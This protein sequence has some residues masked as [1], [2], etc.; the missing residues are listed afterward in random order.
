MEK[1]RVRISALPPAKQGMQVRKEQTY[2]GGL[3]TNADQYA[4][5]YLSVTNFVSPVPRDQANIE[6]EKGETMITP[7]GDDAQ[8]RTIPKTFSIG[9]KK[10]YNGGTP[11]N[12]PEGTFIYSDHL[13]ETNT[14][15][16]SLFG[17]KEKKSGYTYAELSKP[18]MLNDDIKK[19]IDPNSDKISI[20]TAKMNIQNKI[21]KLS[22]LSILQESKKGFGED[23]DFD[24]PDIAM[25]YLE[26]SGLNLADAINPYLDAIKQKSPQMQQ[27]AMMQQA[28]PPQGPQSPMPMPG[29][30]ARKGGPVK[31]K[32]GGAVP[33]YQ[34]AG[35]VTG[36]KPGHRV[37]RETGQIVDE[38]GNVVGQFKYADGGDVKKSS[39]PS[40]AVIIKRSD[41]KTEEEYIA[42]RDAAFKEQGTKKPIYV[43]TAD[44][45]YKK[46]VSKPQQ[47]DP[48][49]GELLE[50]VFNKKQAVADQY[51]YI[52]KQFNTPEMKAALQE[53]AIEALND[54]AN[55]RGITDATA[56][57]MIKKLQDDPD[58]AYNEFM[59]MQKRNLG[60]IAHDYE[61][62]KF[63]NS[64]AKGKVTNKEF[65][66]AFNKVGIKTP[67]WEDAALQQAAY[68]GYQRLLDDRDAGKIEDKKLADN[69]SRFTVTQVGKNDDIIS[70]KAGKGMI[71]AVD[72]IYTNTTAGQIAGI[73]QDAM[74]GEEDP[75]L[76]DVATTESKN[77]VKIQNI[78]DNNP[79]GWRAPDIKR[80]ASAAKWM[81][82]DKREMPWARTP[83]YYIPNV[84]LDSPDER[85][86]NERGRIAALEQTLGMYATPGALAS[87]ASAMSGAGNIGAYISQVG[88]DNKDTVNKHMYAVSDTLNKVAGERASI[89]TKTNE[90]RQ[91]VNEKHREFKR[92]AEKLFD[93]SFDWGWNQASRLATLNDRYRNFKIDPFT[94]RPYKTGMANIAP[95]TGQEA[96]L[97]SKLAE[98]VEKYPALDQ[99]VLLE[100]AKSDLGMD[101]KYEPVPQYMNYGQA[102]LPPDYSDYYGNQQGGE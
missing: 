71:S 98:Y 74:I 68:I 83:D 51:Y 14:D 16:H 102:T 21:Q 93:D 64:P 3:P 20:E 53:K 23:G 10:H 38:Y 73:K 78:P 39:I 41:Y 7:M 75:E 36:L 79:Y 89:A 2:L 30:M 65:E 27:Q 13:K 56:K 76:V 50:T 81:T 101:T 95:T 5:P 82:S 35:Q 90:N 48:Y 43:Q 40:D 46:V 88:K 19:L 67:K 12:V 66:E 63:D 52:E 91:L 80:L 55:R 9:G 61:P 22:L 92:N 59:E 11:L 57:T 31:M 47:F 62:S 32:N 4:K 94:G 6:A 44:G 84:Y 29:G 100:A 26:K 77:D 15:V 28:P 18:Y 60:L 24:V 17:K 42:A 87:T 1:R 45:K 99:K 49:T 96:V 58:L 54:K 34:N 70:G 86:F 85:A 69:L 72:G 8:T 33:S 37:D 25:P 97:M